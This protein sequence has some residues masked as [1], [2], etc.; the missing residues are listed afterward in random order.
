MRSH[1]PRW[2]RLHAIM[3]YAFLYLPIL[4]LVVY[5]FNGEGVGGFPPRHL[6]LSWYA[7]L[8]GDGALWDSVLNSVLVALAA[9]ALALLLGTPAAM[10]LDRGSFPGKQVFRCL[11][12]FALILPRINTGLSL[13]MPVVVDGVKV[14]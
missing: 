2:L 8:A 5:S 1:V 10:A 3:L 13:L 9:V 7:M 4:V 11:V 14:S 12:L 6:T